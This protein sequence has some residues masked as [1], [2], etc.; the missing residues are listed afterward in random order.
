MTAKHDIETAEQSFIKSIVLKRTK[1]PD[2]NSST[3]VFD[4]RDSEVT[5]TRYQIHVKWKKIN[6]GME[7]GFCCILSWWKKYLQ[8]AKYIH[9]KDFV[10]RQIM[11]V[12]EVLF[13]FRSAGIYLHGKNKFLKLL[14][15]YQVNVHFIHQ[16]IYS[17]VRILKDNLDRLR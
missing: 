6:E 7:V 13:K 12:K 14:G 9:V 11:D 3:I 2:F 16:A 15:T 5:M 1:R 8:F 10:K 17:N 4:N